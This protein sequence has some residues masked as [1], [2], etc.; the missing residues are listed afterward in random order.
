MS[1]ID[2]I[3][4]LFEKEPS[5]LAGIRQLLSTRELTE[6]E[7][8]KLAVCFTDMCFCEYSDA[9]D[10]GCECVRLQN[11]HSD[12]ILEAIELLL[13]FGLN[14]NAIVAGHNVIWNLAGID[15]PNVAAS[16]LQLLLEHGGNPNHILSDDNETIFEYLDFMVSYDSYMHR[17]FHIV[18]CWLVCMAYGACWQ[19]NHKIPLTMLGGHTVEIFRDFRLYDYEIEYLPQEPGKFGC[20]IMHIFNTETGEEVA[21][22]E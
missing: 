17:F 5:D 13:E 1:L 18:Q 20:W 21:R 22:F 2:R 6:A 4:S 8:A 15:A 7:L 10:P 11:L 16:V 14:P 9:F 19:D 12:H 3:V